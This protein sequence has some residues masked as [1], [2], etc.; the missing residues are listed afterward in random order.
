M[1]PHCTPSNGEEQELPSAFIRG[2][3]AVMDNLSQSFSV[4]GRNEQKPKNSSLTSLC[5]HEV[6]FTDVLQ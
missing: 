2:G 3:G 6:T 1:G 5:V 4:E